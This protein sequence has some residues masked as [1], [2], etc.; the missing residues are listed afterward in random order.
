MSSNKNLLRLN[1]LYR[2]PENTLTDVVRVTDENIP[3]YRQ[4]NYDAMRDIIND[5][6]ICGTQALERISKLQNDSH[7]IREQAELKISRDYWLNEQHKLNQQ[8]RKYDNEHRTWLTEAFH[9]PD[10]LSIFHEITKYRIWL[11]ENTIK[12]RKT[13]VLPIIQLKEELESKTVTT[14]NIPN[15]IDALQIVKKEQ[16]ELILLLNQE[17]RQLDD[18]LKEF[19]KYIDEDDEINMM[20]E[21]IPESIIELPCPNDELR[22]TM[23]QE[24]LIIDHKYRETLLDLDANYLHIINQEN[25]GWDIDE[26]EMLVHLYEMY[27]GDVKKRRTCIYNH[28]HRYYP[29]CSRQEMLKHEEWCN[30]QTYYLKH[31]RLILYEWKQAR[32]ALKLKAQLAFQE[33]FELQ[34]RLVQQH[35]EKMKQRALCEQLANQVQKWREKQLEV[36][37]VKRKLEESK[38]QAE[39]EKIRQENEQFQKQRQQTKE[40][41][42]EYHSKKEQI[43]LAEYEKEQRRLDEMQ[44]VLAEQHRKDWDR[45]K[46]RQ[47]EYERKRQDLHERNQIEEREEIEREERL[48]ALAERVRPH[49]EI[50]HARVLQPTKAYNAH[51]GLLTNTN[52]DINIQQELFPIN[53]FNDRKLCSDIRIRLEQRLR[54]A[55]LIQTDYARQA[56]AALQ[57][58][59]KRIDTQANQMWNGFTFK[60][61][62]IEQHDI[63]KPIKRDFISHSVFYGIEN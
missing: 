16:N 33:A 11:D 5:R 42:A 47:E 15:I 36:L 45:I 57:K 43:R 46:F 34:E 1:K 39:L 40:K 56:L 3:K 49:V 18:E 29:K 30:A 2:T 62:N 58:A 60:T 38:R 25:D 26:H 7:A 14:D 31:K 41:L 13:T 63:S 27:P 21:G 59:P 12:F 51:R 20:E 61:N 32:I 22:V 10:L 55:G 37:E 19:Q 17:E 53:T 52:D 35:E 24:F 9:D 48:Q 23:L 28:F 50:D 6:K 54:D 44:S 4:V 8:Y